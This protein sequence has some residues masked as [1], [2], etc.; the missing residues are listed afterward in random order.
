MVSIAR[1][2]LPAAIPRG[3]ADSVM[4]AGALPEL[5]LSVSHG[6]S[7]A[8]VQARSPAP[9]LAI[10]SCAVCWAPAPAPT[11]QLTVA[12]AADSVGPGGSSSSSTNTF[13]LVLA[14]IPALL[15]AVSVIVFSPAG[16]L[17]TVTWA[18][19]PSTPAGVLQTSR[20]PV[21]VPS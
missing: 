3:S 10:V 19:L 16:S 18:P 9:V 11:C 17:A 2:V 12:G 14:E 5:A 8:A 15:V 1:A 13:T 7:T 20:S 21:I 4:L 6:A